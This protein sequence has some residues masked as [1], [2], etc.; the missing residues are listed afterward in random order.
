MSDTS[1]AAP[2]QRNKKSVAVAMDAN[3]ILYSL[4]SSA[5]Y[6]PQPWS[7]SNKDQARAFHKK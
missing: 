4:S 7:Y 3:D 5:D 2:G 1:I 6:D